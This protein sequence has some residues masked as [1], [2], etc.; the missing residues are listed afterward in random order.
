MEYVS[1]I[2][3]SGYGS[4]CGSG[5]GCLFPFLDHPRQFWTS[6]SMLYLNSEARYLNLFPQEQEQEEEEEEEEE[7]LWVFVD[8]LSQVKSVQKTHVEAISFKEHFAMREFI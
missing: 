6:V 5:Y 2:L 3:D 1:Q 7:E 8:L 4:G